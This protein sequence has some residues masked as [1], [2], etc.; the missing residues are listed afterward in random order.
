MPVEMTSRERVRLAIARKQPDR[1]P[2]HDSPW[3]ATVARW[4]TEGLPLDKT[5]ADYF[6]YEV[7]NL[8]GNLTPRLPTQV[9]SEDEEYVTETTA[10]GGVRRN[11]K[12]RST[13]PE[14]IDTP[15]KCKDDWPRIKKLLEPDFTRFDWNSALNNYRKWRGEGRYIVFSSVSGYDCMQIFIRS[16]HLLE[17]MAA[18]PEWIAEVNMTVARLITASFDLMWSKGFEFDAL[19]VYNDMGYRNASLFSP[20]MYREM[21]QPGDKLM[22]G[23]AHRLGAQAILHSCGRVSGLI[24]DLLDSGLDCLQ[25][26][27]VKAGMDP[28]AI[29]KEFGYR[30]AIF[31]GIDTRA[32]EDPDPA[33]TERE[34]K[35]KLTGL[36]PGGGYLFHSDHSVPKDVSFARYC[37]V[38][39]WVRKYGAY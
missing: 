22:W 2:I 1:V 14:I 7:R 6:G 17:F 9:L 16:E 10:W 26:L 5:P 25:P 11:H 34:I 31:G 12:D 29:K 38:M 27:E 4:R 28:F 39:E 37:Q 3:G 30:L 21:I 33:V 36:K 8:G 24:P 35:S 20:K 13:T 18:D 23:A 15:V 19:W 32:I